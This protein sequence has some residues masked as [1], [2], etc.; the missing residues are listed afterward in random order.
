MKVQSAIRNPQS[1]IGL[2]VGVVGLGRMG[3]LHL[4]NLIRMSDRVG[5]IAACDSRP[6][7]HDETA[8]WH[9]VNLYDDFDRMIEREQPDAVVIATTPPSH[10][11]LISRAAARGIHILCEKPLA[12]SREDAQEVVNAVT[13]AGVLFQIAFQRRFDRAYQKAH[14][15]ISGGDIGDPITFKAVARDAGQPNIE[16][17][18][19]EVSGGLLL[20]MAIHDFDLARWLMG[21]E[22]VRVSTEG[23]NLLYPQ[24]AQVGDIDNAVVNLTFAS[25][26]IGNI[27]ASRTGTYGYDIRTEVVGT[28]GALYIGGIEESG[29]VTARRDS[30]IRASVAG[31]EE[32]FHDSYERELSVFLDCVRQ[33]RPPE[34]GIPE[35]LRSLEIAL[36]AAE[37]LR[38]RNP[39]TVLSPPPS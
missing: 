23:N 27:E 25:G 34:C 11:F 16:Y 3:K 18:R 19:P 14:E 28:L 36:A 7:A 21:S 6:G 30:F 38:T 31:F 8:G 5:T 13:G 33:N 17:A 4:A 12:L 9:G 24:L 26:A 1:A 22:V 10:P 35:A 37:S 39:V 20:D 29:L 2:R 32:R 15:R